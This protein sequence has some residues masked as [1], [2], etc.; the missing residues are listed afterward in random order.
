MVDDC[1]IHILVSRSRRRSRSPIRKAYALARLPRFTLHR[2]GASGA[3][4]NLQTLSWGARPPHSTS[5]TTGT[6]PSPDG[7]RRASK[8]GGIA[9]LQERD[10]WQGAGQRGGIV[11]ERLRHIVAGA[12]NEAGRHVARVAGDLTERD[13]LE[14]DGIAFSS[15]SP[16]GD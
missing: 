7:L 11:E 2:L 1:E 5:F 16:D 4:T 3:A 12:V 10:R 15:Q 9:R 13:G 6:Q 8:A 14:A